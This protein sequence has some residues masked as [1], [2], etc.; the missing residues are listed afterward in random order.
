MAGMTWGT[1]KPKNNDFSKKLSLKKDEQARVCFLEQEPEMIYVHSF[2]KVVT[3]P[4]GKPIITKDEWPDGGERIN[5]KTEYAG[6]LLCLG[7]AEVVQESGADPENCSACAAHIENPGALKKPTMRVL[8][9]AFKY[10]TKS[11]SFSP[12]KPFS[13][14]LVV[15]DLTEKRFAQLNEIFLEHG[16]L[17]SKDLLLGPC[18]LEKMQKFDIAVG[19]GDA[20][21]L[22]TDASRAFVQETLEDGRVESL[23]SVAGKT[24]TAFEMDVKVKE[25][26]RAYNH[27]YGIQSSN[28]SYDSIL[29]TSNVSAIAAQADSPAT[30]ASP[31]SAVD[32]YVPD[33]DDAA[34]EAPATAVPA[35]AEE[36]AKKTDATPSLDSLLAGFKK[37]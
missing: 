14:S 3:G 33:T 23:A 36:T 11:G 37:S 2:E 6:K 25:V 18:E 1:Y 24:P 35:P 28:P 22:A 27:A 12:T 30:P 19:N 7:K 16:T 32:D 4:D 17:A 13:G 10:A 31:A 5:V 15:W 20:A 8:G 26:V 29:G 34:D 21:W 9:H